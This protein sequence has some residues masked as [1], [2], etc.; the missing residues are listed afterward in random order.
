[1]AVRCGFLLMALEGRAA[2]A[3]SRSHFVRGRP[4]AIHFDSIENASRRRA[5]FVARNQLIA[6]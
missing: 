5:N 4:V 3:M 6:V 1:M 2:F